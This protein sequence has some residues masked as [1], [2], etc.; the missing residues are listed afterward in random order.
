M[1]QVIKEILISSCNNKVHEIDYFVK[2]ISSLLQDQLKFNS[3]KINTL[4]HRE[5]LSRTN[6]INNEIKMYKNLI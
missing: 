1:V 4:L 3:I 2:N 5:Q 6:F